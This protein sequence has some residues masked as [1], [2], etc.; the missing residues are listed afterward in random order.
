MRSGPEFVASQFEDLGLWLPRFLS[1]LFSSSLL[2]FILLLSERLRGST[3][4]LQV[5]ANTIIPP[6]SYQHTSLNRK[7][8]RRKGTDKTSW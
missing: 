1:L 8:D 7:H 5:F 2:D 6:L 4:R 3:H